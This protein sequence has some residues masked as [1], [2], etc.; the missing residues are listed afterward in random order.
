M[1]AQVDVSPYFMVTYWVALIVGVGVT[2]LILIAVW[3][4]VFVRLNNADER[5]QPTTNEIIFKGI[6]TAILLTACVWG[7]GYGYSLTLEAS[8]AK[9]APDN[10]VLMDH[11][12]E[13]Q[14]HQEAS[15]EVLAEHRELFDQ[16][17]KSHKEAIFSFEERMAAEA[18]KIKDRNPE[19]QE[20]K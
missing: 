11:L 7:G 5:V 2:A 10:P 6:V 14:K 20:K 1:I 19:L 3:R 18:K 9:P 13:I 8:K 4:G 17:E 15:P 16:H 12:K